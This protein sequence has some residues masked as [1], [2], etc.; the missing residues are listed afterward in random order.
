M[1]YVLLNVLTFI[2]IAL[3][4]QNITMA[5]PFSNEGPAYVD[6]RMKQAEVLKSLVIVGGAVPECDLM[7]QNRTTENFRSEYVE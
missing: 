5:E 4:G 1:V 7:Y 3:L 6:L 2:H